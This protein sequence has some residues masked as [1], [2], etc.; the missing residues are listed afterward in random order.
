LSFVMILTFLKNTIH[1][2]LIEPP[3][4]G[5]VWYLLMIRSRSCIMHYISDSVSFSGCHIPRHVMSTCT[6]W[7]C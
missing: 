2:F 5:F 4:F 3:S 6:S 1:I 7:W